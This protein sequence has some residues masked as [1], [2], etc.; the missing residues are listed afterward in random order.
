MGNMMD[1]TLT[2]RQFMAL[3]GKGLASLAFLGSSAVFAA[4]KAQAESEIISV[5]TLVTG[6]PEMRCVF[7]ERASS[8]KSDAFYI[9]NTDESGMEVLL[10]DGGLATGKALLELVGLRKEILTRAGLQS[11]AKNGNYKLD[12]TLLISHFHSDHV[13]ELINGVL[14]SKFLRVTAAYMPQA[15]ALD[16]S[17]RYDNSIN[18]DLDNRPGVLSA[19]KNRHADAE[20]HEVGWGDVMVVPMSVGELTLYASPVDWGTPE[21]AERAEKIYYSGDPAKRYSDMPMAVLNANCLWMRF[22]YGGHSILFTGD[23]MKKTEGSNN[24][25]LDLF[26]EQYGEALRSDIVKFPHHGLSRSAA[27]RPVRDHLLTKDEAAACILTG[28][29]ASEKVGTLLSAMGVKWYDLESGSVIYT[30]TED[31]VTLT[32]GQA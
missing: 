26:I 30:L 15:T 2:R 27:C 3:S 5:N 32:S 21:Y 17:G 8:K 28:S 1:K 4:P 13:R 14:T 20:I 24:E 6:A 12:I 29:D 19:L 9:V 22:A 11:E 7:L 25:S 10:I 16:T 23:V 31:A 18:S